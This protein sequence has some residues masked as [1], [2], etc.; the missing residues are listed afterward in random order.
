[1]SRIKGCILICAQGHGPVYISTHVVQSHSPSIPLI[2]PLPYSITD[3]Y[4]SET[5]LVFK[6]YSHSKPKLK[7][8]HLFKLWHEPVFGVL[9]S[10]LVCLILAQD[11][12]GYYLL[13]KKTGESLNLKTELRSLHLNPGSICRGINSIFKFNFAPVFLSKISRSI[14]SKNSAYQS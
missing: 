4:Y 1:M 11:Q 14:S 5:G 7:K 9:C 6:W 12:Y 3:H 8:V 10:G 13:L 2:R